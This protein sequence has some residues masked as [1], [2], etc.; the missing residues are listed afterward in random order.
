MAPGKKVKKSARKSKKKGK[1]SDKDELDKQVDDFIK[2]ENLHKLFI[3]RIGTWLLSHYARVIDIFRRFDRN[4][5]GL[6]SYEEFFA[7]MKDLQAPCNQLELHVLAKTVDGNGDGNIEYAEFSQGIK[8]RRP[9]KVV[10]DDGLPV[11]EIQRE[12]F[13]KCSHCSI[14]KWNFRESSCNNVINVN[15]ILHSMKS[16]PDFSGHIKDMPVEIDT[17][18]HG[19][20]D[21]IL[22]KYNFSFNE[23]I[24]FTIDDGCRCVLSKSQ[25]IEMLCKRNNTD[26]SDGSEHHETVTLF[27]EMG[28]GDLSSCPII[29]SDHYFKRK[30]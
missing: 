10:I 19:L 7:G 24:M 2:S 15:V 14:K 25:T 12:T 22:S 1:L 8:Y 11:L 28:E 13:D 16:I 21:R 6:L 29:Q 9:K 5:D 3:E 20:C 27:Y 26:N 4:G 17:T 23:I 18:I 30:K